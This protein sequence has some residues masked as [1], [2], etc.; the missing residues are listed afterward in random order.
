[1]THPT[2]ID[3]PDLGDDTLL[4]ALT[5]SEQLDPDHWVQR[6]YDLGQV[7]GFHVHH[8]AGKRW[9]EQRVLFA[10]VLDLPANAEPP[11]EGA[12]SCPDCG[13][14]LRPNFLA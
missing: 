11:V 9:T 14:D 3:A 1:M 6:I 2:P 8:R 5:G 13:A 10:P 7:V 4:I 12:F